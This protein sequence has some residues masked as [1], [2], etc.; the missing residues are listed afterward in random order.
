MKWFLDQELYFPLNHFHSETVSDAALLAGAMDL[1]ESKWISTWGDGDDLSLEDP[2]D[3]QKTEAESNDIGS[4]LWI[5]RSC[6]LS[7]EDWDC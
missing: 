6:G 3:S 1:E 5:E 7:G 4:I 2:R